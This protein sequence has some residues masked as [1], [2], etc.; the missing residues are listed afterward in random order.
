M[1]PASDFSRRVGTHER[2][3]LK[4]RRQTLRSIWFGFGMFGLVGWSVAIPT[5]FGALLGVKLDRL[6]PGAHSWTLSFLFIG[7]FLG[8]LNAWHWLTREGK[9]IDRDNHE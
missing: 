6:Y 4:A 3:K 1:K 5:I 2:R 8:A 9:E 7:L